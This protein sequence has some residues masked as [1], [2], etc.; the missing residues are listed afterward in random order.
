MPQRP[1]RVLCTRPAYCLVVSSK[2]R[3]AQ[4]MCTRP[5]RPARVLCTR[6]ANT[7]CG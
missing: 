4:V 7:A 1:T 5:A 3:P 6:P 2:P